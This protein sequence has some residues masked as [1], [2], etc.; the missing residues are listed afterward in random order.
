M[1]SVLYDTDTSP[2]PLS[3]VTSVGCASIPCP[4]TV[5]CTGRIGHFH[6]CTLPSPFGPL[7]G[8]PFYKTIIWNLHTQDDLQGKSTPAK[9]DL[10]TLGREFGLLQHR[11]EGRSGSSDD[12]LFLAHRKNLDVCAG[13]FPVGETAG[14]IPELPESSATLHWLFQFMYPQ[15]HP[16]LDDTTAF[17]VLERL[18][19]GAEKYQVFPA[20]EFLPHSI[21]VRNDYVLDSLG[22]DDGI[23]NA[24]HERDDPLAVVASAVRHDYPHAISTV[25]PMLIS[26]PN[27]QV[28]ELLPPHLL[29]PWIRYREEWQRALEDSA[30]LDVANRRHDQDEYNGGPS[31]GSLALPYMSRFA[32][33]I[34]SLRDLDAVFAEE[35]WQPDDDLNACCGPDF[36]PWR[37]FIEERV[38]QIPPFSEF[39]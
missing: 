3:T 12:V 34:S 38:A 18:A 27:L 25:A 13:G 21:G 11:L 31:Y 1:S 16:E 15:R 4:P 14:E 29:F 20:N 32:R 24:V 30:N 33:G 7:I 39:L 2:S 35:F 23:R 17:K 6:P 36:K 37:K 28:V 10:E 5:H 22:V 26:I 9:V 19:E 8:L